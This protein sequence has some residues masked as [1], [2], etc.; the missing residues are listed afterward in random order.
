MKNTATLFGEKLESEAKS[1]LVLSDLLE[2][3]HLVT[4]NVSEL[5]MNK[6]LLSIIS[7]SIQTQDF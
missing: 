2:S 7:K 3:V 4:G 5:F 6:S 1:S